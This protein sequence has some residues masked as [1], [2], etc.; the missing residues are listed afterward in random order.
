MYMYNVCCYLSGPLALDN[1]QCTAH[2]DSGGAAEL[3]VLYD[4][5]MYMCYKKN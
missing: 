5:Q 3:H 4:V 2:Y 1:A